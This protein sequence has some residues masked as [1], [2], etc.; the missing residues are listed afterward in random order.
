MDSD[1]NGARTLTGV[2]PQVRLPAHARLLL[3]TS[4]KRISQVIYALAEV[5]VADVLADGPLPVEE[6]AER[7]ATDPDA[8]RRLLRCAAAVGVFAERE[9]GV[10]ALTETAEPLRSDVPDSQRDMVLFNGSDLLWFPYGE[11]VSGLRTGRPVFPDIFGAEFFD[12]LRANPEAGALFDR[13]MTRMSATTTRRFLDAYDFGRFADVADVGGG[14]GYFLAGL[15]QRHP[16]VHGTLIDQPQVISEAA[17]VMAEHGV[18]DRVRLTPGDFFAEL[19]SGHAAYVL[20]AVLHDWADADATAILS[21]V[22]D[23]MGDHPGSRLLVLEHVL[24]SANVWDHGKVLDI[25]MMLRFGGR[26]RDLP[27][28]R[29]LLESA[30]FRIVND[31]VPGQWAVIECARA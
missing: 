19:P 10:F 27:E 21:Q 7:T 31:P 14:R 9:P 24:A 29:G 15:L 11:I 20:K 12:H 17:A 23:A 1:W 26:E 2:P 3:L 5:R 16:H 8:L 6:I 25:D 13:A 30:G 22:R 28:W 18:A 4:G